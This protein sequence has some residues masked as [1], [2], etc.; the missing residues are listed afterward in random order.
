MQNE[1]I[2]LRILL[3]AKESELVMDLLEKQY[4]SEEGN[5]LI[6][7]PVEAIL[8]RVKSKEEEE[9]PGRIGREELYEDIKEA[10]Q[11]S[12]VYLMMSILATIVAA[13]GFYEN[14]V[15]VIIGA[16]VIAPLIGPIVALSLAS[17]LGDLALLRHASLTSIAGITTSVIIAVLIGM[18]FQLDL[19][20]VQ[21][22]SQTRIAIGNIIVALASGCA[23]ALA[24]ATGVSATLIGVMVA[25]ALLPPLVVFGMLLGSGQFTLALGALALFL[26]NV[27]C[28]NLSGMATF[29]IQGI[30]PLTWWEKDRAKKATYIA[31][32][33]C[34]FFL[35]A[36]VVFLMIFRKNWV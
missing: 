32:G 14:S 19:T 16:M 21:M 36:L 28:I 2:L 29:L 4:P 24:F 33:L 10:A 9:L 27:I 30:S 6:V 22:L 7:L 31:I 11:F 23:G 15:I 34:V 3:D 17:T 26:T 25:V 35:T 8:P 13:I 1:E 18:V 5:R 12:K 20:L